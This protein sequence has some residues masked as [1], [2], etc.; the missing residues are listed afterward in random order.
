MNSAPAIAQ[1]LRQHGGGKQIGAAPKAAHDSLGLA[2]TATE[3]GYMFVFV[4][5]ETLPW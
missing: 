1:H 2:Y 4:I 3:E 5:N